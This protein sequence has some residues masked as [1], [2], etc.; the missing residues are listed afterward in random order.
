MRA[1]EFL[2]EA[3][4]SIDRDVD[5]LYH[6]YIKPSID[7]IKSGTG[8]IESHA[9]YTDELKSDLCV[10]ANELN[11]C[12]ILINKPNNDNFY[13]PTDQT[14]SISISREAAKMIKDYGGIDAALEMVTRYNDR[15]GIADQ[16]RNEFEP[17]KIKGSI[18]H[19]LVHWIDD[20]LHNQ[21]IRSNITKKLAKGATSLARKPGDDV[22]TYEFE[23]QSQIHNIYQLK[24]HYPEQWDKLTFTQ[25][26]QLSGPLASM[27]K[28][29][30]E[31]QRQEWVRKM[32]MRMHREGLL[33]KRMTQL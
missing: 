6:E 24:Q 9:A 10:R 4:M 29:M 20:T 23:R 30:P 21:H 8:Y 17:A 13:R 5:Y 18:H 2:T 26:L 15:P 22:N 33:G 25:M 27:Y 11:P 12:V 3:L 19:E 1:H 14:I 32:R 7:S 31:S 28:S 16:F